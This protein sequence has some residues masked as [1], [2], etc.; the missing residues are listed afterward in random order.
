MSRVSKEIHSVRRRGVAFSGS[1][2]ESD[3]AIPEK[4]GRL[5][6]KYVLG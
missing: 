4:L 6:L 5:P 3:H 2:V 1:R